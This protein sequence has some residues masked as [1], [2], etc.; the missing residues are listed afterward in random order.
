MLQILSMICLQSKSELKE[1]ELIVCFFFPPQ[2]KKISFQAQLNNFLFLASQS[3][4]GFRSVA[5]TQFCLLRNLKVKKHISLGDERI[6]IFG[7]ASSFIG[8]C[9]MQHWSRPNS[10]PKRSTEG[11]RG[12]VFYT[13]TFLFTRHRDRKRT[14]AQINDMQWV[15]TDTG[16]VVILIVLIIILTFPVQDTPLPLLTAPNCILF[17][18]LE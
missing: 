14:R 5:S 2:R 4:L 18:G 11:S 1:Q 3:R 17:L 16:D 9:L 12:T 7:G 8:L 13:Y 6:L 10:F 15:C